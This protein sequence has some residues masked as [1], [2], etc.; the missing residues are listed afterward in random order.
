M[1]KEEG[2]EVQRY[3]PTCPKSHTAGTKARSDSFLNK[4]T[5]ITI[6]RKPSQC[7]KSRQAQHKKLWTAKQ[8][9]NFSLTQFYE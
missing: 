3:F 7:W 8:A 2:T 9:Q 5:S 4:G 1:T 6:H